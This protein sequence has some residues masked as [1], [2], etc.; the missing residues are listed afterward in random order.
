[1]NTSS[2]V[3]MKENV[4]ALKEQFEQLFPGKWQLKDQNQRNL[5]TGIRSLDTGPSRGIARKHISEWSGAPS[6]GKSTLLR[7]I[8]ANWCSTGLH[9][10]YVDAANKLIPADW[11]YVEQGISGGTPLNTVRPRSNKFPGLSLVETHTDGRFWVVRNLINKGHKQDALWATEQLVRSNLFDVVVFDATESPILNSRFY[12]RLQRSL[13]SSKAALLIIKDV[14][15]KFQTNSQSTWGCSTR[16]TF[17]WSNPI[18]FEY[19]LNGIAA[20]MPTIS[21]SV[22]KNGMTNSDEVAL[23]AYATN[24]LFTHP[25]VPDRR[26]PKARTT[27]K[28]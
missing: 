6:S 14:D 16:F 1:M 7:A 5:Y 27:I 25:Q 3:I 9:I 13:D 12:A 17:S 24:R 18:L 2:S 21:S 8:V 10:V 15:Q 4:A 26:V 20:M 28:K 11:A 23:G 22:W 19:G